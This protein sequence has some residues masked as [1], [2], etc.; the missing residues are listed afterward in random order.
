MGVGA[1]Y[2]CKYAFDELHFRM[3]RILYETENARFEEE[4]R[5]YTEFSEACNEGHLDIVKQ[6][7]G[8]HEI[9]E[10][11][12]R[13][14]G[15]SRV[16]AGIRD[17][18]ANGH[19]EIMIWLIHRFGFT[20]E[21]FRD[22]GS[23]HWSEDNL[24]ILACEKGHLEV[25]Q[26]LASYFKVTNAEL[27]SRGSALFM[28]CRYRHLDVAQWIVDYSGLSYATIRRWDNMIL[29]VAWRSHDL[30]V[31]QWLVKSYNLSLEDIRVYYTNKNIESRMDIYDHPEIILWLASYFEF[32]EEDYNMW[33]GAFLHI[34]HELEKIEW[35][36]HN[37]NTYPRPYR[38][39]MKTLVML[40]KIH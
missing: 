16:D 21:Y 24:L 5:K 17:A 6:I 1:L 13:C 30:E 8:A 7:I 14:R 38:L 35:R 31:V 33:R 25:A 19:L 11:S 37:H 22:D 27:Y 20:E 39:A 36:P 18:C 15:M 2:V 29:D 9:R 40:A 3:R 28:A 23:T 34:H 12:W 26:W 32:T 4:Q 10:Y